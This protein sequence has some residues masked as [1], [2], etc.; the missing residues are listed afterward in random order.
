MYRY[1]PINPQLFKDNRRKFSKML[2]PESVAI[3]NSNDEF[4]RSND[5]NFPFRQN[6]DLFYLTGINQ[7]KTILMLYPDCPNPDLREVL[8]II[9]PSET[10]VIWEGHKLSNEEASAISGINNIRTLEQFDGA[11]MD[12][13]SFAGKIYLNA[14]EYAKFTNEVPYRDLR[15]ANEIREKFPNHEYQRAA[16]LVY[17]LRTIKSQIEIDLIKKAIDMTEKAFRRVLG[18]VKPGVMEYQAQAWIEHEYLFNG[19]NGSAYQTIVAAGKNACGLHYNT[20]NDICNDGDLLLMD[21]GAEYAN[22]AADITRTIPVNGRFT[23]RQRAVYDAIL[24]VQTAAIMMFVP[25]NTIDNLNKEVNKLIE[26]ELIGLGL[27]TTNDV[28]KQDPAKPLFMK[29]YMHGTS[30]FLGL[31]VHDVGSK[32]EPFKTGMVLT[33]EPALYIPEENMGIRLENNIQVTEKGPVD[34]A[35]NIPIEA[36]EIE[37]LMRK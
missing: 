12:A 24:R 31:D 15:F 2:E 11:L 14:I 20:N 16:P 1:P 27:F 32:F 5:Q 26:K 3:F 18:F 22:Y 10:L 35:I 30:H 17:S 21:F 7:E 6:S 19:A 4:P 25:G 8:F 9:K 36:E 28:S 37:E 13:L 33:C 23:K 34:L 29:Y